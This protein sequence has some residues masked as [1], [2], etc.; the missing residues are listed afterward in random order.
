[1]SITQQSNVGRLILVYVLMSIGLAAAVCLNLM[2]GSEH[3]ALKDILAA[4]QGEPTTH[5]GHAFI[6]QELRVPRALAALL[7]GMALSVSGL[8]MQA[9]FRN[10][11][12]GP[13]VLGI[14][15][16]ASLGVAIVVLGVGTTALSF[17][18][19]NQTDYVSAVCWAA[20]AGAGA[21]SFV[22]LLVSRHVR[23]SVSLLIFGLMFGY[24]TSGLVSTL[25]Y[26]SAPE[27]I[28]SFMLWNMGSFAA[29]T[30]DELKV[31]AVIVAVGL[32]LACVMPKSLN[33]MML[34][35]D[36]AASM[37]VSLK[38]SRLVVLSATAILAGG[39]TAFCGPIAFIGLAVPHL[40]RGLMNTANQH[41]LT[42]AVMLM[43]GLIAQIADIVSELPGSDYTLPLNA[44]TVFVGA[45][46]VIWVILRRRRMGALT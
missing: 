8:Q 29:V 4:L 9:L 30:K 23:D 10:P 11:L 21:V 38:V 17:Q 28:Q 32:A 19:T 46:V 34:G 43:G 40:C 45:P 16:G 26:F 33:A 20:L 18:I 14:N 24:V 5:P 31:M 35:E 1:M 42:P 7:A 12:A 22:V 37:G 3:I 41:A 13:Y 39:V 2:L 44:I 27:N 25:V 6:I 15:S 36:Y